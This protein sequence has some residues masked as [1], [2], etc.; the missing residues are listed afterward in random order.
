M[1]INETEN[2]NMIDNGSKGFFLEK[3]NK[4]DKPLARMIRK[5]M[6]EDTNCQD[7]E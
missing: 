5:T 6:R 7:Q 2:R 3:V 4:I 1:E